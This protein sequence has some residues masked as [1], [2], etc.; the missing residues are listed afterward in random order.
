[1]YKRPAI[2]PRFPPSH[3]EK[4]CVEPGTFL[5]GIVHPPPTKHHVHIVQPIYRKN[6][7]IRLY[8]KHVTEL[9]LKPKELHIP[10]WIPPVTEERVPECHI[11]VVNPIHLQ[12][13]ILKSGIVRVKLNTVIGDLHDAY[14]SKQKS[15]PLKAIVQA[16]KSIGYSN[17]FLE[18]IIKSHDKKIKITQSFNMDTA[19][20]KEPVKKKK[21]KEEEPEPQ[22]D[23]EEEDDEEEEEDDPGEDGEM[24]VERDDD[25]EVVDQNA[26]EFIDDDE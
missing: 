13:R 3:N 11:D 10:E 7:Y 6:D 12:L 15:A 2:R 24:D 1:M 5:H 26:E 4:Y 16:Y 14:Y 23:L 17:T 18:K 19:F 20:G 25:D 8:M 9:G 22:P 21:K